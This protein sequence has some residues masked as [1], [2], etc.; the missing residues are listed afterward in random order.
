MTKESPIAMLSRL[1]ASSL[2]VFA[3]RD[4]GALGV[5]RK[6]LAALRRGRHR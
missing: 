6:Q 2:G 5:S 3:G 1:S 4:A